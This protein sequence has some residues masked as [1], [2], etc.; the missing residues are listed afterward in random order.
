MKNRYDPFTQRRILVD[1]GPLVDFRCTA[2]PAVPTAIVGPM[3]L[4]EGEG[5][6]QLFRCVGAV[7][8]RNIQNCT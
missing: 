7:H 8:G 3:L 5:V 2:Q 1:L 6:R 4:V